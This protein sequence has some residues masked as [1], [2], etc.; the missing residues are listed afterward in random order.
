LN[1][2]AFLVRGSNQVEALGVMKGNKLQRRRPMNCRCSVEALDGRLLPSAPAGLSPLLT[3]PVGYQAVAPNRPIMPFATPSKK[4]TF[5]DPTVTIQN[6]NSIIIGYQ[7]FI[8]PYVRLDGR[9]GAIKVGNSS[10]VLDNA[11]IVASP[12]RARRGSEVLIGNQV[13]IGFGAKVIGPST[14]GAYGSGS[15]PTSIGANALID[16]ATI[17]PGA[18]VSPLA[19]VGPGVTVKS[20]FRVVP[21]ANITTDAEASN[22]ALGMVVPVTSADTAT[23]KSTL[24]ENASLATGYSQLYQ[25]NS[26]TGPNPGANPTL[27]GINNG[28][29]AAILGANQEPGPSSAP[30]EPARSGPQFL[31]PHQGLIGV[32]LANFPARLTG[33]VEIGMRASQAAHHLGRANAIRADQGQPITISSLR[34]TA[35]HVTINSPLGGTLTIGKNF[36]AGSNVVLLSGPRV[37]VMLG[38]NVKVGSGA[39]VVQTS[40]GSNSTVGPGA[41]LAGS[42]FP[43]KTVIPAKAI[44]I[45][46]KFMGYVKW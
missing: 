14:I 45:N 44:Y 23:I 15:M 38:D 43:A 24:S 39:V 21:G 16:G 34:H 13:V 41:Y 2:L 35:L 37:N 10:N 19:R 1:F 27:G 46:N 8:G 30:F 31:A 36:R 40:L 20:R 17:Q 18:I 3:N 25:G 26:A 42:T 6:G 32:M 33:K 9:G 22:P 7:D 29:L 5:I 28:N 11:S 12:G 4:A